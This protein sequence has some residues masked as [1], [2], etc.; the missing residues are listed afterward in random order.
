MQR[1]TLPGQPAALPSH[2]AVHDFDLGD[3]RYCRVILELETEVKNE[4]FT[5]HA[6]AY[7]MDAAGQFVIAPLGYPSRSNRTAHTVIASALGDTQQLEDAWVRHVGPVGGVV[8]PDALQLPRVTARPTA[9]GAEY[10][11]LVWDDTVGHAWRWAEG[12]ADGT[13]RTKARDL[14][15]VLQSSVVRSGLGFR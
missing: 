15:N 3:G 14:L 9:P 13:A 8:D 6:Q 5:L 2:V 12:F 4:H 7:E 10:G 11:A 1:I